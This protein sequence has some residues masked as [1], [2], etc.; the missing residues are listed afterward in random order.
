MNHPH[1]VWRNLAGPENE[2]GFWMWIREFRAWSLYSFFVNSST[3]THSHSTHV[4]VCLFSVNSRFQMSG[5]KSDSPFKGVAHAGPLLCWR[6]RFLYVINYYSFQFPV[7][8]RSEWQSDSQS[9]QWEMMIVTW[10][11]SKRSV[12]RDADEINGTWSRIFSVVYLSGHVWSR[13]RINR[14]YVTADICSWVMRDSIQDRLQ[15]HN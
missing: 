15:K 13:I 5:M 4:L 6:H 8:V 9:N 2:L 11:A 1:K 10:F 14:H 12:R 3:V 7:I